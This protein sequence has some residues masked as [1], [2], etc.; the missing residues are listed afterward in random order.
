MPGC[1]C[2]VCQS[3]NPKNSRSRASIWLR[4]LQSATSILVDASTDLRFQALR[5]KIP[6][7]DAVLFTHAHADHILGIEDL[8]SYNFL[9]KQSIP[10]FA[11]RETLSEIKRSFHYIFD[12]DPSYEG[13]MLA[14]LSLNEINYETNF[15]ICGISFQ[16]IL[17]IHGSSEASMKVLGFRIGEFAY[18][19][20]CKMIPA[21]SMEV[22]SGVRHLILDGLR[23]EAHRT[24][25]T[26]A[27]AIEVA[28]QIG[29][30]KTYFTHMSHALEY[31]ET[32]ARLPKG[33]ELAYD[34]L[35][36]NFSR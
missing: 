7:L 18:C 11:T 29:A 9:Q 21:A 15:E 13:G 30:E 16:P 1:Q 17:L 8:R 2:P 27:E 28:K 34:G 10:C 14:Q 32:N 31:G 36:I 33:M 20:D 5:E 12:P 24:H 6:R 23:D 3:N 4:E 35:K 22:L 19:T 26:I 25:F